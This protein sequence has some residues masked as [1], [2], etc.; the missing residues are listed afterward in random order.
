MNTSICRG[1]KQSIDKCYYGG[2]CLEVQ[3]IC[4]EQQKEKLRDIDISDMDRECMECG[5]PI[6]KPY[7]LCYSCEHGNSEDD[8]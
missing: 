4:R 2:D 8:R 7:Y 5:C 3:A 1:C 6:D